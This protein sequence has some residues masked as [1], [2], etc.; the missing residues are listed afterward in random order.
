MSKSR[1][2]VLLILGDGHLN[3][4]QLREVLTDGPIVVEHLNV[5][6]TTDERIAK[7]PAGLNL[8][9]VAIRSDVDSGAL[10]EAQRFA[11]NQGGIFLIIL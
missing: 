1:M 2:G 3:G 11:E 7:I 10:E 9:A 6:S 5:S 4:A 8:R